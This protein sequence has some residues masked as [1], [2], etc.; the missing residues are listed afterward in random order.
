MSLILAL[1]YLNV[2]GVAGKRVWEGGGG[3][4]EVRGIL[5]WPPT[6]IV[7][8]FVYSVTVPFLTTVNVVHTQ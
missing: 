8:H 7:G 1:S 4:G 5:S 3:E 2:C 6:H